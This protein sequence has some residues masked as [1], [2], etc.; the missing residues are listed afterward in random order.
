M[1]KKTIYVLLINILMNIIGIKYLTALGIESFILY[2]T[3]SL[4]SMVVIII[5][6]VRIKKVN[7]IIIFLFVYWFLHNSLALFRCSFIGQFTTD[8]ITVIYVTLIISTIIL[9]LGCRLGL[10]IPIYREL[11]LSKTKIYDATF[12]IIFFITVGITLYKYIVAG[13]IVNYINSNYETRIPEEF[14]S[15]IF[16]LDGIFCANFFYLAIIKLYDSSSKIIRGLSKLY[17][18]FNIIDI[19]ISG[20]SSGVLYR[21]LALVIFAIMNK[22]TGIEKRRVIRRG[23]PIIGMAAILGV[24]IRFNRSSDVFSLN[25]L[26][27][28]I[29]Q[30]IISPTF[31]CLGNFKLILNNF[32]PQYTIGQFIYP[33]VNFIPRS[34]FQ[35]K[36][37]ELSTIIAKR[38]YNFGEEQ[39]GGFA[40]SMMG[41]FYYDFGFVG[42]IVGIFLIGLFIGYIQKKL[43]VSRDNNITKAILIQIS[44]NITM[45]AN[46]YTGWAIRFVYMIVFWCLILIINKIYKVIYRIK[47]KTISKE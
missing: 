3:F 21:I 11:R 32:S 22:K 9:F 18:L 37:I 34:I 25:V 40:P 6:I 15:I 13:G 41:E 45:L 2:F 28:M 27:N 30:L 1:E 36:P 8:D 33:F 23:I 17:I 10:D 46:W 24:L 7:M 39:N 44:V 35:N 4:L 26:G 19:V 12:I 5:N 31:D 20:K 42:I 14:R 16:I 43:N 47:D 38:F 29:D